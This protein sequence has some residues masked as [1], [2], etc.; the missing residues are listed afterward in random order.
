MVT[1]GGDFNDTIST[2]G[3][4]IGLQVMD[5]V[6]TTKGTE[7]GQYWGRCPT[8]RKMLNIDKDAQYEEGE[9][10]LVKMSEDEDT[11]YNDRN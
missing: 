11:Q 9:R 7:D 8:L 1:T 3:Q 5:S 10:Y 2:T 6:L 4:H